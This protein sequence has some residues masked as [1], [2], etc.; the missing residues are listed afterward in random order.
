[1]R[2][3][4]VLVAH[5]VEQAEALGSE[6]IE[7]ALTALLPLEAEHA[8]AREAVL[9]ALDG[10]RYLALLTALDN[11][12]DA[13]PVVADASPEHI[14]AKEFRKLGK[15]LD[16][17]D[18]DSSDEELHALRIRGK[19]ARYAAE[20]AE[21]VA[22]KPRAPV[23]REREAAPGRARRPPGRDRRRGAAAL[24]APRDEGEERRL[25]ARPA[26]RARAGAARRGPGRARGRQGGRRPS[27]AAGLGLN[28]TVRAAGGVVHREGPTGPE[29]LL[30]HRP[31]YDDWSFPKG[32]AE[33]GESDEDCALREVE[34]ETG[35]R[36]ELERELPSTRYRDAR[37]RPKVVRYWA[38]H[39]VSGEFRPHEEVDEIRWLA[40]DEAAA[41]LSW[42]RD[43]EVLR[44]FAEGA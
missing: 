8:R 2:D 1:M 19:K 27:R 31:K 23:R 29:V 32:K 41:Q 33:P 26:R 16:A 34:E 42:E 28:G 4:D 30:V 36:C 7:T 44:A 11:S 3:L 24:A 18:A 20:L 22:G 9:E 38:M 35:L 25:R 10:E 5:L 13:P 14:A 40:P 15:H 39:A 17:V 43:L 6:D 37:D 21:P 12:V